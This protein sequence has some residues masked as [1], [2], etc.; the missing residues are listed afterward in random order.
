M[1]ASTAQ[2]EPMIPTRYVVTTLALVGSLAGCS[3]VAWNRE[4]LASNEQGIELAELDRVY[5][6]SSR[7]LDER[8]RDARLREK[9]ALATG[10]LYVPYVEPEGDRSVASNGSTLRAT[11]GATF[12][13]PSYA[14]TAGHCVDSTRMDT[15]QLSVAMFRP[16]AR[17]N[18]TYLSSTQLT[19]QF[20]DFEHGRLTPEDGYLVEEF[21]CT[22][23][24]RCASDFG[25][26][27]AC[28]SL[29]QAAIPSD[30]ALIRCEGH[31]ANLYETIGVAE[32]DDPLAEVFM[33]WKHEIYDVKMDPEDDRFIHYARKTEDPGFNYHYF[34]R[35]VGGGLH[36]QLLPLVSIPFPD[37]TPHRKVESA[38]LGML[39]DLLGCHG[40]SGS[41]ALQPDGNGAFELLG[42]IVLGNHE[43]ESYLCNHS[44]SYDGFSTNPG[45]L[46]LIYGS[47]DTLKSMLG[48]HAAALELDCSALGD[49]IARRFA[50]RRCAGVA[51]PVPPQS[52]TFGTL[53]LGA[54]AIELDLED[55]LLLDSV[56][57]RAGTRY[58]VG[59]LVQFAPT[60]TGDCAS[61]SLSFDGTE[62]LS[63]AGVALAASGP[64]VLGASFLATT[65]S[66]GPIALRVAPMASARVA[67]LNVV[68]EAAPIRF[69][70][71]EERRNVLLIDARATDLRASPMRVEGAVPSGFSGRIEPE[72]RLLFTRQ[73]LLPNQST[74]ATFSLEPQ[75]SVFCGI[76]APDGTRLSRIDCSSGFVH[77]PAEPAAGSF[78]IESAADAAPTNIDDLRLASGAMPDSDSDGIPDVVDACPRGA[79]P[80]VGDLLL[81]DPGPDSLR[82]CTPGLNSI[83]V[84]PPLL[85]NACEA[86]TLVGALE[87]VQ[88]VLLKERQV[89]V[90]AEGTTPPLPNGTIS[91]SYDV[92]DKQGQVVAQVSKQTSLRFDPTLACCSSEQKVSLGSSADEVFDYS[93][94][95]PICAIT[96]KGSD[97][98]VV[99]QGSSYV[100]TGQDSD[101]VYVRGDNN[102]L[103]GGAGDDYIAT[104]ANH[105]V[106]F[107]GAGND[108]IH[109]LGG[110]A[111]ELHGGPGRDVIVGSPG[112]DTILPGS[113]GDWVDAGDGD[114]VIVLYATCELSKPPSLFGGAGSD[115]LRSP[116]SEAALRQAGVVLDGIETIVVDDSLDYLSDCIKGGE[117]L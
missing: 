14:V 19:G 90:V 57:L 101:Y 117:P 2:G 63:T 56:P 88:G 5:T 58:R 15:S 114:D 37:G 12:I 54:H 48:I 103:I 8:G 81:T 104:E 116:V 20:P 45:S 68:E 62:I 65:D 6:L 79:L 111:A 4:Y 95:G 35:D 92:V 18:Q 51:P 110:S 16:T 89:A 9:A 28:D 41:G 36:N 108:T 39:T 86:T 3:E 44:P 87:R 80:P 91:V 97:F 50:P 107:G 109:A 100:A 11:C 25:G 17:L 67:A 113:G 55:P 29:E 76:A 34:D 52:S 83:T 30:A 49:S 38:N 115:T 23:V 10:A 46:G 24:A 71:A 21:P 99:A 102:T 98:V 78:Y 94:G 61:L 66:T 40:T 32:T 26:W 43:L 77:L 27:L 22:L 73:A 70:N 112:A 93:R 7:L 85:S 105:A 75:T 72:E 96:G 64:T 33:P 13:S 47:N 1:V 74:T 69:D 53:P 31:P 106:V 82:V 60:C 42:P 84:T 59:L